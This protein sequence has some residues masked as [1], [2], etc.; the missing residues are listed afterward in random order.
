MDSREVEFVLDSSEA[1]TD[2]LQANAKSKA[3]S[4]ADDP[5]IELNT[6]ISRFS[7]TG[8]ES[9]VYQSAEEQSELASY[10][11]LPERATKQE[12]T[13]SPESMSN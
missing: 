7:T 5:E 11:W 12:S 13:C 3:D 6:E 4:S 2:G 8:M 10:E 9:G 1:S